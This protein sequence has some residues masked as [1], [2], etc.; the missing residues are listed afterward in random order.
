MLFDFVTTK[1]TPQK[2]TRTAGH[3]VALVVVRFPWG[4]ILALDPARWPPLRTL[5]WRA[6]ARPRHRRFVSGA[7]TCDPGHSRGQEGGGSTEL[8]AAV[9]FGRSCSGAPLTDTFSV[10]RMRT[11]L[12]P[13]RTSGS[14]HRTAST[15]DILVVTR[16]HTRPA[17]VPT[18]ALSVARSCSPALL[19]ERR[20]AD[21]GTEIHLRAEGPRVASPVR[22]RRAKARERLPS[23]RELASRD[24]QA[25]PARTVLIVRAFPPTVSPSLGS[26]PASGGAASFLLASDLFLQLALRPSG[27]QDA[28]CVRPTSAT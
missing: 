25:E 22:A 19:A 23:H 3:P 21:D 18:D 11:P 9:S 12:G 17:S 4:S 15:S 7:L 26:C 28:R 8:F 27:E 1:P 6:V 5:R 16:R 14:L 10:P 13:S 2:A 20:V 24:P